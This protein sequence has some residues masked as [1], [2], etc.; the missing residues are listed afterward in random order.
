[1]AGCHFRDEACGCRQPSD[2]PASC[3]VVSYSLWYTG[4]PPVVRIFCCQCSCRVW[5]VSGLVVLTH[6]TQRSQ[7]SWSSTLPTN[8]LAL[9]AV[10][11]PLWDRE[12]IVCVR[13]QRAPALYVRTAWCRIR[14]CG[15]SAVCSGRC[16][17]FGAADSLTP[18][19][20]C[21]SRVNSYART[22]LIVVPFSGFL[23]PPPGIQSEYH[24]GRSP[25]A[26][27]SSVFLRL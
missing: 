16:V 3:G 2:A 20:Y 10:V 12:C 25:V 8:L 11:L 19:A 17:V 5:V 21:P 24:V 1:M 15:W 6:V 4:S 26:A 7:R 23:V 22:P 14:L 18:A 27:I 9:K 13:Y